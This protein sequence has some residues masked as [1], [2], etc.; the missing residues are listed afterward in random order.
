M[1][2]RDW[3]A[4]H[5]LN[6]SVLLFA[7]VTFLSGAISSAATVARISL[8]DALIIVHPSEPT[9]VQYAAR[10]LA[11]YLRELTGVTIQ[12]SSSANFVKRGKVAI[13]IGQKMAQELNLDSNL[14]NGL[15][16]EGSVIRSLARLGSTIVLVA[17]SDPHGTNVGVAT[18]IQMVR[19]TAKLHI[20]KVR[21][22]F[23]ISQVFRFVVSI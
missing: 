2:K 3:L 6:S 12:V 22:I 10:D 20:L 13:V 23:A 7:C 19:S 9:Y 21:S 18:L 11:G 5:K 16:R 1:T 8:D 14:M 4:R 15:G 17:G